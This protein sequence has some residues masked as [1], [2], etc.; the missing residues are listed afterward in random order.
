MYKKPT[1]R[2]SKKLKGLKSSVLGG[3]LSLIFTNE[4]RAQ[5]ISLANPLYGGRPVAPSEMLL[6]LLPYIGGV[7]LVFVI[8][9]VVGL[10]WYRK[11]GGTKK[12]PSVIVRTLSVL[13]VLALVALIILLFLE[14]IDQL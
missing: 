6:R 1:S 3:L 8:A 4:T 14:A 9:P 13:F 7:F 5:S 12:W 10:I 2:I 11:H